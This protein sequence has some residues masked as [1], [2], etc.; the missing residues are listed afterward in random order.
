MVSFWLAAWWRS[1]FFSWK[2]ISRPFNVGAVSSRLVK[3]HAEAAWKTISISRLVT[4]AH[5]G[6]KVDLKV[7]T[8]VPALL[9][10][11]IPAR[12]LAH[13]FMGSSHSASCTHT[14]RSQMALSPP[15]HRM[16]RLVDSWSIDGGAFIVDLVATIAKGELASSGFLCRHHGNRRA[17]ASR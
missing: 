12:S 5:S 3:K 4:I 2:P 11:P 9:R 8:V 6:S 1:A 14:S 17:S 7:R 10:I 16:Q 13:V 15:R